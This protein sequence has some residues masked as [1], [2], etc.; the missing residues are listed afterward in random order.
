MT[1]RVC[2]WDEKVNQQG[3]TEL[4]VFFL[5]YPWWWMNSVNNSVTIWTSFCWSIINR[6]RVVHFLQLMKSTLFPPPKLKSSQ[7]KGGEIQEWSTMTTELQENSNG[8]F[9]RIGKGRV[10]AAF[11]NMYSKFCRPDWMFV[12]VLPKIK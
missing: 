3:Y 1:S 6:E 11:T 8:F 7:P 2:G 10:S 9:L 5:K 12:S 4:K